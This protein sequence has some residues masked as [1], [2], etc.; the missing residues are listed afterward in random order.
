[1]PLCEDS[2]PV[3]AGYVTWQCKASYQGFSSW[4]HALLHPVFCMGKQLKWVWHIRSKKA[5]VTG[6][7]MDKPTLSTKGKPLAC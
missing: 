2:S 7:S 3:Q 1:M 6:D 5:Q 4:L